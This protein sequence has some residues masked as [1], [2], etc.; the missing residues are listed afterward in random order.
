MLGELNVVTRQQG[1]NCLRGQ[2]Q[3]LFSG[4]Q[5]KNGGTLSSAATT[6]SCNGTCAI[7]GGGNVRF[8]TLTGSVTSSTFNISMPSGATYAAITMMICQNATGGFTFAP[9]ANSVGFGTIST[10]AGLCSL[11]NF[12]WDG[13]TLRASSPIQTNE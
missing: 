1:N 10:T 5:L 4:F 7:S 6:L 8:I 12:L 9:P 13:T 11:Q 2:A 3:I